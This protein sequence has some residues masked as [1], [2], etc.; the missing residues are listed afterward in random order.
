MKPSWVQQIGDQ[1]HHGHDCFHPMIGL[2][3]TRRAAGLAL[4]GLVL[5]AAPAA[6]IPSHAAAE[7]AADVI[8]RVDVVAR[9]VRYFDQLDEP[10]IAPPPVGAP[11]ALR[12]CGHGQARLL[13][14]RIEGHR[15][16]AV[17]YVPRFSH[18][19]AE[20]IALKATS[21]ATDLEA[22]GV[23]RVDL[24]RDQAALAHIMER[25]GPLGAPA[26]G[27]EPGWPAWIGSALVLIGLFG[28]VLAAGYGLFHLLKRVRDL[29]RLVEQLQQQPPPPAPPGTVGFVLK[30]L[31]VESALTGSGEDARIRIFASDGHDEQSATTTK[32]RADIL[33]E[34]LR[35]H[36]DPVS[37]FSASGQSELINPTELTRLRKDLAPLLGAL[38]ALQL[39]QNNAGH[40]ALNP[41][42]YCP[43][44]SP[45]PDG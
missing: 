40:A 38:L 42:L 4:S 21:S 16:R 45:P 34:L 17:L 29:S 28:L 15:L 39:V 13:S 44:P 32:R 26:D 18:L 8:Y 30:T 12:Y 1:V 22:D 3:R 25:V 24:A 9:E 14:P 43:P 33:R 6:L 41:T 10:L 2:R 5:L 37:R 11:L 27:G 7:M 36:P 35:R 23:E 19:C 31:R 20:V